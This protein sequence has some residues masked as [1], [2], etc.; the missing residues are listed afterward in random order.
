MVSALQQPQT[1]RQMSRAL[2]QRDTRYVTR[3]LHHFRSLGLAHICDYK[4]G[5]GHPAS[6]WRFGP[7][8][9]PAPP[10]DT[11]PR[12][13]SKQRANRELV[14]FGLLL[15]ALVDGEGVTQA[16]LRSRSGT[17]DVAVR[18]TVR[19][20]RVAK[21]IYVC[22]WDRAPGSH[23]GPFFAYWA[24]GPGKRDVPRPLIG[25]REACKRWY[26]AARGRELDTQMRSAFAA[27]RPAFQERA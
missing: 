2:G 7:G 19:R 5:R 11:G 20:L 16:E 3:V 10:R 18:R 23:S 12:W 26:A 25:N 14:S 4:V 1:V 17:G 6:V 21:L 13:A 22:A 27:N 15:R 9:E 24:Y 8:V